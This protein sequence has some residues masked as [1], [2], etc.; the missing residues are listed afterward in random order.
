MRSCG[1]ISLTVPQATSCAGV[2]PALDQA[3]VAGSRISVLRVVQD[4]GATSTDSTLPLGRR[5]N[6]ASPLLI[7]FPGAPVVVQVSV[8]GS[9]I[10]SSVVPEPPTSQRPS[11]STSLGASPM[12]DQFPKPPFGGGIIVH[13]SATGS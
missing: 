10:A 11:A 2:E 5:V 6:P 7:V 13:V 3:R 9:R 4:G 12:L 1:P 8:D